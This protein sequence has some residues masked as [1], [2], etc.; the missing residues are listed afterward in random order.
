MQ[1]TVTLTGFSEATDRLRLKG[2]GFRVG[3]AALRGMNR[4]VPY[5]T[6]RLR[7]GAYPGDMEVTYSRGIDYAGYVY[8]GRGHA[9]MAGTSLDWPAAYEATGMREVVEEIERIIAG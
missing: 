3:Q 7:T 5:D 6:F 9:H 4:H 8:R 2:Q 1:A